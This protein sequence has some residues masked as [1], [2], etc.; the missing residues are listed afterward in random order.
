MSDAL[1]RARA[2][3]QQ[4]FRDHGLHHFDAV[5]WSGR[6]EALAR[7][8]ILDAR[9][10]KAEPPGDDRL[11]QLERWVSES[12]DALGYEETVWDGDDC[13]MPLP[14]VIARDLAERDARIEA[15][16]RERRQMLPVSDDGKYV[17]VDGHGLVELDFGE[18]MRE[19]AEKAEAA[20]ADLQERVGKARALMLTSPR[21]AL[22]LERAFAL[23]SPEGEAKGEATGTFQSRVK[24]WMD[25]CFGPEISA[26]KVER[27]H[28][29][30]EE[31]LEFVQANGCTQSEAHQLVDYVYGRPVGEINQEV[32][33]VMV[34]LA[35]LCLASGVD[36]HEAA[37]TELARVWEKIDKI[38]AKQAAKPKH[39]PL[40][41]DQPPQDADPVPATGWRPV[42]DE[43]KTGERVLLWV[44]SRGSIRRGLAQIG[45]WGHHREFGQTWLLRPDQPID[46]DAVR[47]W[48]PIEKPDPAHSAGITQGEETH[49]V[50]A[51]T[52]KDPTR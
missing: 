45:W 30:I 21:W 1:D 28:R 37:E 46:V 51:P 36:M 4:T 29:F 2:D 27:N 7:A 5:R 15:L 50:P 52:P 34:T 9:E 11:E 31:A 24:P 41:E 12:F 42:T 13:V 26:D 40:P 33:G 17:F 47:L 10:E 14:K 35:A 38:R 48:M 25:A 3:L 43:A 18:A 16:E 39:S 49:A 6:I 20:L 44:C 19:R 8:T 22:A 32:G 23:L